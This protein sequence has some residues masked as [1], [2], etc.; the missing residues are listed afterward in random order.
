MGDR[1]RKGQ[2]RLVLIVAISMTACATQPDTTVNCSTLD[3]TLW[4]DC[5]SH[6]CQDDNCRP[7]TE[8]EQQQLREE[9]PRESYE[10]GGA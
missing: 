6:L 7:L 2:A 1:H 10:E 5:N 4:L 3:G 9:Q 8:A